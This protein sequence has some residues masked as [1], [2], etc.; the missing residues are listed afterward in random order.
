MI[1]M[2][3]SHR[4]APLVWLQQKATISDLNGGR[5]DKELLSR[6][7]PKAGGNNLPSPYTGR[8][9]AKLTHLEASVF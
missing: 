7:S 6:A 3:K 2:L 8:P 4:V 9:D 1:A 5:D